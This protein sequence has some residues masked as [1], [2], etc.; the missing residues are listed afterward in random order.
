M[1]DSYKQLRFRILRWYVRFRNKNSNTN[2]TQ[3]LGYKIVKEL[4]HNPEAKLLYSQHY[5]MRYI[6]LD[7][8]FVK[9]HE[10]SASIINGKYSYFIS[11]DSES[12]SKLTES[13]DNRNESVRRKIETVLVNKTNKSLHNILQEV[14]AEQKLIISNYN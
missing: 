7:D 13:F 14:S 6:Q 10:E 5:N 3:K 12:Y 9:L 2:E 1:I 4:L 11:L 8:I